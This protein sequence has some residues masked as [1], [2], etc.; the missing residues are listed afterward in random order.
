MNVFLLMIALACHAD[1]PKAD[2]HEVPAAAAAAPIVPNAAEVA[3]AAE[4]AAT[5]AVLPEANVAAKAAPNVGTVNAVGESDAAKANQPI[6]LT[7]ARAESKTVAGTVGEV[8]PAKSGED[9]SLV[10]MYSRCRLLSGPW[11]VK[12]R[13]EA[14]RIRGD[15]EE[16]E[17]LTAMLDQMVDAALEDEKEDP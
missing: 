12:R 3:E 1:A 9:C 10:G 15:T 11:S 13:L 16:E 2:L 4:T 5:A 14:A 8:K 7:E 6:V 17:R